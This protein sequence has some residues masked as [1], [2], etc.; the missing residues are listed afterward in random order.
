MTPDSFFDGG[1]WLDQE[2]AVEHGLR[3][4]EQGAA[5]IDV[6]GES[7]RPG[8]VAV[9]QTEERRRV[10]PVLSELARRSGGRVRLSVDTRHR[11]VAEDALSAGATMINDISA[12]LWP[13]AAEGGAAWVAMHMRGDPSTMTSLAR[14]DDVV[15]EVRTFLVERAQEAAAGGVKE[16]WVDPGIGFAKTAQHNLCLLARLGE[17]AGAGWPVLVGVSRKRFTGATSAREEDGLAP[18]S[19]RL[20]A[21]LAAAV[22]AMVNGA[23]MVRAHDVKA[24]VDAAIVVGAR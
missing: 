23:A 7:T 12:S 20:P 8:A 10:L 19:E 5:V 24:T 16:V 6:G 4:A 2:A 22:W 21:S 11:S 3:M 1:R 14:Y 17:L 13:V 9:S 18:V 15:S